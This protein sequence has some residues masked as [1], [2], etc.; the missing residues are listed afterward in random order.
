MRSTHPRPIAGWTSEASHHHANG[1]PQ[2]T[3]A[4]DNSYARLPERF[5]ARQAPVPVAQ[6]RLIKLNE[7]ARGTTRA[8][9]RCPGVP[10]GSGHARGQP[11]AGGSGPA[12]HGLCRPPVRRLR[13]PAGRWPGASPGGDPG[14][15]RRALRYSAQ[16]VRP[17]ALL[18][19]GDGRAW[20]GPVLREYI[21]SEAM[22]ALG[23]PTTRSLAAVATGEPVLREAGAPARRRADARGARPCAGGHFR[24]LPGAPGYG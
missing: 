6:P 16:G 7:V 1:D 21:L 20:V 19:G 23:I 12:G 8:G 10:G 17:H 2:M 15:E 13:A 4:F 11:G 5:F 18:P 9:H 24:I 22:Q 14:P 3:F